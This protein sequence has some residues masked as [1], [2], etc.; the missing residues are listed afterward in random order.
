MSGIPRELRDAGTAAVSDALD[1]GG[2]DGCLEGLRRVSG[3]GFVCGPAFT[4]RY[5]RLRPG[6]SGPA[7]DFIDDVPPGS[8]VVIDNGGLTDRTVWGDVLSTVAHARGIVGTVI[9]GV[10]R[11]VDSSRAM[12][13]AIWARG[14]YMRSG[15]NRVCLA[16][17]GVAVD[18]CGVSVAPGDLVCADGSG[19]VVVP[20]EA[21]AGVAERTDRVR[22]TERRIIDAAMSGELL[23]EARARFGYHALARTPDSPDHR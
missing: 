23:S 11:D 15:K 19:V 17:T 6:E 13:Y 22:R 4:V 7:G 2:I 3:S 14:S 18:V 21:V 10:C 8:V 9:D 20:R 1:M 16:E 5:R 12:D